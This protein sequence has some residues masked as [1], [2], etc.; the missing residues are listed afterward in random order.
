MRSLF[1]PARSIIASFFHF[2]C[3][4]PGS[5]FY[6]IPDR[7]DYTVIC[8]F[9]ASGFVLFCVVSL[10]SL[11]VFRLL[12]CVCCACRTLHDD[13]MALRCLSCLQVLHGDVPG[14]ISVL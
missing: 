1:W 13:G 5:V 8:Y 12:A 11:N 6:L 4:I 7:L 9:I 2:V 10:F 14:I 3:F